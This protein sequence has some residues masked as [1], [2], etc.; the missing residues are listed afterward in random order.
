MSKAG[1]IKELLRDASAQGFTHKGVSNG[2]I[3]VCTPDRIRW[4]PTGK[5]SVQ[6]TG[7]PG[8][9]SAVRTARSR[10]EGIGYRPPRPPK[11][12]K[13]HKKAK[14]GSADVARLGD[15]ARVTVSGDR[16][17]PELKTRLHRDGPLPAD[18]IMDD[19]ELAAWLVWE[20]IHTDLQRQGNIMKRLLQDR[21]H[22]YEWRG[23]RTGMIREIWP[24]L[25]RPDYSV[26]PTEMDVRMRALSRYLTSSRNMAVLLP[27]DASRMT[28]WWVSETWREVK[29]N[30]LP[31]LAGNWWEGKV[32]P[33]EAG[34][35][36]EPGP[37]TVTTFTPA[38][39]QPATIDGV[40]VYYCE[41][42]HYRSTSKMSVKT[43]ASRL[44]VFNK[45]HPQGRF[46][47]PVPDCLEVR[48]D[49]DS[50]GSHLSRDHRTSNLTICRTCGELF[51]SRGDMVHHKLATHPEAYPDRVSRQSEAR[52][53][54]VPAAPPA[55]PVE[56]VLEAPPAPALEPGP[57][58]VALDPAAYLKALIDDNER[59]REQLAGLPGL[60]VRLAELEAENA[61][62]RAKYDKVAAWLRDYPFLGDMV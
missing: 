20:R 26:T 35:D 11:K 62:L 37:V 1:Q 33:Q 44:R 42:C 57:L 28:L 13:K 2:H 4:T 58:Q 34:E 9:D 25:P 19:V 46:E 16:V 56:D 15:V 39:P 31:D 51:T 22:G 32:T 8:S 60:E 27:G 47:C 18:Q 54:A 23:S 10:L 50:L 49:P 43:H 36:R 59:M 6:I 52:P 45:P 48:T 24:E 29:P 12:K 5:R 21:Y 40:E 3:E 7:T 17:S 14:E 53:A 55:P 61:E 38:D 41:D 30:V